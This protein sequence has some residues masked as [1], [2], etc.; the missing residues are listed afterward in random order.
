MD[1]VQGRKNGMRGHRE[2]PLMTLERRRISTKWKHLPWDSE[3]EGG[4][5]VKRE[6]RRLVELCGFHMEKW[7][8]HQT[9]AFL[10]APP[11]ICQDSNKEQLWY[12]SEEIESEAIS[13]KFVDL[14]WLKKQQNSPGLE[15]ML[16]GTKTFPFNLCE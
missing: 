11:G 12:K 4:K 2:S 14:R 15:A 6:G 1:E 9:S 10:E 7:N 13:Q 16:M 8:S 3:G 5:E